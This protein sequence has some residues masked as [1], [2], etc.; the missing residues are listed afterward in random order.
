MTADERPAVESTTSR[1]GGPFCGALGCRK[2]A[3]VVIDHPE[4]GERTVCHDHAED[5]EV[6]RDVR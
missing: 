5:H 2:E 1:W 4:H 6:V 3:A